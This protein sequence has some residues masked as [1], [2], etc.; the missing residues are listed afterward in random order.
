MHIHVKLFALIAILAG[1]ITGCGDKLTCAGIGLVPRVMPTDTTIGA[2][3]SF[4]ARLEE[5]GTC[6]DESHAVYHSVPAT[7]LTSDTI[8]VRVDSVSGRVTG[9]S[10]GDAHIAALDQGSVVSVV[11]VHVR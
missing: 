9:R 8:V 4:V 11:S 3:T 10:V 1:G 7:W 2:G 5:G 6:S